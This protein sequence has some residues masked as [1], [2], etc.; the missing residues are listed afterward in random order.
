[1]K[2]FNNELVIH[3]GE[4]FS[5]DKVVQNKDGSPYIVSNK[6]KILTYW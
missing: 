3:R 5:M 4:T 6:L 2:T 1:M